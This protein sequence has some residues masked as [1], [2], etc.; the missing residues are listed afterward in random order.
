MIESRHGVAI[1]L[2]NWTGK[3]IRNLQVKVNI[4]TPTKQATLA[5]GGD[6]KTE[7]VDGGRIYTLDI[8]S[9]DALILR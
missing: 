5:S 3:P 7:I 4:K 6:L 1:P 9:A 8:D 2:V